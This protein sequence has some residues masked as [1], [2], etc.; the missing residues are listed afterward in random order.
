[1]RR[2]VV[3][4][5]TTGRRR[6]QQETAEHKEH[7]LAQPRQRRQQE[8]EEQEIGIRP[9]SKTHISQFAGFPADI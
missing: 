8:T 2:A 9:L 6:R 7:R 1:M 4:E 3:H 5:C